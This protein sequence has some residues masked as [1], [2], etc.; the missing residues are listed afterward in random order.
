ML[1]QRP[2]CVQKPNIPSWTDDG[3]KIPHFPLRK[4][5]EYFKFNIHHPRAPYP[6]L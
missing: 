6:K 3:N 4:T 2:L 1:I 5:N